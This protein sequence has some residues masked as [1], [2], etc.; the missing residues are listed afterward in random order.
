MKVTRDN[1]GKGRTI[2]QEGWLS[3]I[4]K[5]ILNEF[6][7][8]IV[9]LQ[10]GHEKWESNNTNGGGRKRIPSEGFFTGGLGKRGGGAR[11]VSPG[12]ASTN[13]PA[14]SHSPWR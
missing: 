6:E 8:P 11:G 7:A 3:W 9:T 5:I 4:P 1:T 13:R 10:M 2:R 14:Q 12:G